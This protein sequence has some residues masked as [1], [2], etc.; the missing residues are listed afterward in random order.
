MTGFLHL[1]HSEQTLIEADRDILAAGRHGELNVVQTDDRAIR[2]ASV[3]GGT[4]IG[5][6]GIGH[7]LSTSFGVASPLAKAAM[8]WAVTDAICSNALRVKKA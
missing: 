3:W 1:W 6:H 4:D 2:I 7:E 5:R 8:F